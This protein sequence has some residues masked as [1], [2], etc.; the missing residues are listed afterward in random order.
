MIFAAVICDANEPCSVKTAYAPES[1]F[2]MSILSTTLPL[3]FC[4]VD[5]FCLFAHP[6][7]PPFCSW[8]FSSPM[9]ELSQAF[10]IPSTAAFASGTF[11]ALWHRDKLMHQVVMCHRSESFPNNLHG[12]LDCKDSARCLVDSWDSTTHHTLFWMA[13]HFHFFCST[14][15]F[16]MQGC[17]LSRLHGMAGASSLSSFLLR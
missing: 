13:S 9:L 12:I 17:C 7:W 8:L 10:S 11:M 14:F 5:S 16:T 6:E 4:K 3:Y 1:S 15:V 2:T